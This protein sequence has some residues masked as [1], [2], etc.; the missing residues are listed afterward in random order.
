MSVLVTLTVI[1]AGIAG[2]YLIATGACKQTACRDNLIAVVEFDDF[3]VGGFVRLFHENV[4]FA[5]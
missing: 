1:V 5:G 3:G 4:S 2:M